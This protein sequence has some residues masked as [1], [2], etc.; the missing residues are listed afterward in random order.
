MN[1]IAEAVKNLP[2]HWFQGDFGDWEGN[3][4][5]FGHLQN[6]YI[7]NGQQCDQAT[8]DLLND[9]AGELFPDR[10]AYGAIFSFPAFNDHVDTTE[11]DVVAVMEKAAVRYDEQV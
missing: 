7:E 9:V 11:E 6:V 10:A 4:C 3:Y 5:G 2:G 1:P 8:F